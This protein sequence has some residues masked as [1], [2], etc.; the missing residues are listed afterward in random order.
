MK[1]RESIDADTPAIEKIHLKAFGEKEGPTIAEL[2][3]ALFA[4]E[5]AKPILS[6]IAVEKENPVGHILFTKA[7]IKET[8]KPVA[9]QLLAPLAVLPDFQGRGIGAQLIKQ[10]LAHLKKSGVDL[11]FVLGHPDYYPRCGFTPAGVLGLN[12]PYPIAKENAPA[13]M[14]T[15]LTS[16]IIGKV[17]GTVQCCHEIDQPEHWRE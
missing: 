14:V 13:W 10:G 16:G 5:T 12:A 17:K 4:D 7:T 3:I 2:V 15:G 11:V 9:A 8:A 6:L 1:I